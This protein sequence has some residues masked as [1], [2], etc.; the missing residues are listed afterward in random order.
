MGNNNITHL[1]LLVVSGMWYIIIISALIVQ[2]EQ[3]INP[4]VAIVC[5]LYGKMV[6][7]DAVEVVAS[8][9]PSKQ[10]WPVRTLPS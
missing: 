7:V 8:F 5:I 4:T 6:I 3:K 2:D 1:R 10:Y 9:L